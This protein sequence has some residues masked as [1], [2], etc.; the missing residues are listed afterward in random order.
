MSYSVKGCGNYY[1]KTKLLNGN[2]I[3][4]FSF[5][6]DFTIAVKWLAVCGK[7][8]VNIKNGRLFYFL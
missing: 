5:P 2:S 7:R 1:R 6:K 3:K 8:K 4:Y